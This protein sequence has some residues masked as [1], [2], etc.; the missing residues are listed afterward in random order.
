MK[1]LGIRNFTIIVDAIKSEGSYDPSKIFCW[2]EEQLYIDEADTIYEFLQWI[3][4]GEMELRHGNEIPK[5][6]F[7]HGNYEERFKQFLKQR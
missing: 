5:R 7:G 1:K 2:F 6:G 3:V 4:D